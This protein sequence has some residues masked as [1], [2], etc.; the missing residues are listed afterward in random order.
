[1]VVSYLFEV[2]SGPNSWIVDSCRDEK[3]S[4]INTLAGYVL[5]ALNENTVLI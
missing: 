3:Q 2:L 5:F 4:I 1:M